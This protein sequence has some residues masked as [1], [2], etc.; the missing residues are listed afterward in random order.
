MAM[1]LALPLQEHPYSSW[2]DEE[3]FGDADWGSIV[4]HFDDGMLRIES[5]PEIWYSDSRIDQR[6]GLSR[7]AASRKAALDIPCISLTASHIL[8]KHRYGRKEGPPEG[9]L[10]YRIPQN[11][12]RNVRK[13]PLLESPCYVVF[14]FSTI[15]TASDRLVDECRFAC[16]S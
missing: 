2:K 8:Y 6:R 3:V 5:E 16:C 4:L 14:F 15:E 7:P 9:A 10:G 1:A 13:L 11:R 12:S